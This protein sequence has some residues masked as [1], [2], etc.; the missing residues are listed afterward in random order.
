VIAGLLLLALDTRRAHGATPGAEAPL[1]KLVMQLDWHFNSQFAGLMLASQ[2]GLYRKA[3]LDVELRALGELPYND[4]AKVV[5]ETD[6]MVGSIEAGLFLSGRAAGLPIVA[7][8]TMFQASPLGLIY[9][10]GSGVR[11]PSDLDGKTVSVH[12]DGQDALDAVLI[13]V[14]LDRSRVTVVNSGYGMEGLVAGDYVAKQGYFVDE[15]VK[16][17][18]QGHAA[19]VMKYSDFGRRSYSQ[20]YFVSEKTFRERRADLER[21]LAASAE[22]WRRASLAPAATAE[23]VRARYAP[24]LA[25]DYLEASLRLIVPILTAEQPTLGAMLPETWEA[26][27]ASHRKARPDAELPPMEV[28]VDFGM[29]GR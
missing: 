2:E 26:L 22:G 8:G 24:E 19:D 23:L 9:L 10:E 20:V 13:S 15:L 27:V 3:G 17:R 18:M 4:L 28:W 16:L 25:A 11:G 12:D 1:P 21:F 5:S 29:V 14:G 7:I 6:G